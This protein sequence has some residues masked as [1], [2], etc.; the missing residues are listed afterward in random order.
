MTDFGSDDSS[1]SSPKPK[2][3]MTRRFS[4]TSAIVTFRMRSS[5]LTVMSSVDSIRKLTDAMV[6]RGVKML[7]IDW[8][9]TMVSC[10]TR[11]QWYGTAEELGRHVRPVFRKLII[12]AVASGLNIAVVSFS[13]Q[14]KLILGALAEALPTIDTSAFAVRCSDKSWN[15]PEKA[16]REVFPGASSESQGKLTHLCSAVQQLCLSDKENG[17]KILPKE[18]VFI[19][20]DENNITD[21]HKHKVQAIWMDPRSP[22]M[23]LHTLEQRFLRP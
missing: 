17:L 11:S 14:H 6:S 12:A 7:A 2:K 23:F 8:D 19:D 16:L 22:D 15:L 20:D 21:A 9:L 3:K 5:T 4:D 18:I 13:A 10:H 1:F